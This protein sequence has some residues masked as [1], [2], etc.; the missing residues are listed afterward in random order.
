MDC[1]VKIKDYSLRLAV[2]Y[3]P[4]P[5]KANRLKSSTFLTEEFSQFLLRYASADKNII[6]TGDL[7]FHLDDPSKKDTVKFNDIL[8]SFGMMQHVTESTHKGR[9][10]LDVVITRDT[11][12]TVSD[13]V[14]INPKLSDH[15][16]VIFNARASKPALPQKMSVDATA[17]EVEKWLNEHQFTKYTSF[18]QDYV[19]ADILRL[20]RD[21]LIQIC[22]L[23]DSI[24]LENLLLS[25]PIRT[26]GPRL[27]LF[28]R[29]GSDTMYHAV[30]LE[31]LSCQELI[32][33]IADLPEIVGNRDSISNIC[34]QEPTSKIPLYL[35]DKVVR[36]ELQDKSRFMVEISSDTKN[37][38]N[39]RVTLKREE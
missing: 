18:F 8:H 27:T 21:D 35:T 28:M 6:L 33:E 37:E 13:V 23:A 36:Y 30:Y 22:G 39:V 12:D 15:Y 16:A 19:G 26:V 24:R 38:D 3:R 1:S 2:I 17:K 14:V 7:N 29:V 34:M 9:H 20:T 31:Q 5:S 32:Q 25:R 10:I 4:P 11:V